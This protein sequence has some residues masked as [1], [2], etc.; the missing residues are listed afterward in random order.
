[1]RQT[2][3]YADNIDKGI[4]SAYFMKMDIPR[5]GIVDAGL[6]SGQAGKNCQSSIAY[7]RVEGGVAQ[8]RFY[9]G[10]MARV[11]FWWR[12]NRYQV[13]AKVVATRSGYSQFDAG[14]IE[15]GHGVLQKSCRQTTVQQGSQQ[16]ITRDTRKTVEIG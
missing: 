7:R 6:G 8:D 3:H 5:T 9:V 12:P 10:Q 11:L 14:Q 2:G 4:S 13:T 15:A 1:M 16:H